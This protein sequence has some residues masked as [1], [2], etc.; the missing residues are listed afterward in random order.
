MREI[1]YDTIRYDNKYVLRKSKLPT[2]LLPPSTAGQQDPGFT[3]IV[4]MIMVPT[5]AFGHEWILNEYWILDTG[6]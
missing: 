6:Y 4:P 5:Y 3:S 1:Q 2:Y